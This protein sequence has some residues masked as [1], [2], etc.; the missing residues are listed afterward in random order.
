MSGPGTV[1][2]ES[3]PVPA[4]TVTLMQGSSFT[5][6]ET[7]GDIS[8]RGAEGL[9]VADTRICSKL[10]L[11]IDDAPVEPLAV[12][13]RSPFTASFVGRTADRAFLVFRDL[14][15]GRGLRAAYLAPEHLGST[16]VT[17]A[18]DVYA[19]GLGS[20][21]CRGVRPSVGV[22]GLATVNERATRNGVG[23]RP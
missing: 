22:G 5:I 18:A 12:A 2:E 16:E 23:G 7:S 1:P 3:Q 17:G 11:T 9:F 19:L 20:R 14:W 21:R 4:A 13:S 10:V 15:I 6:C 8:D